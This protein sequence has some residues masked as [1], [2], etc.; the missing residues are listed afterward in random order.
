MVK[1][2]SSRKNLGSKR[3][4]NKGEKN[5]GARGQSASH[6]VSRECRTYRKDLKKKTQKT[7]RQSVDEKK[8]VKSLHKL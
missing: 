3:R 6:R 1:R 2:I 7:L 5:G 4:K 8:Q